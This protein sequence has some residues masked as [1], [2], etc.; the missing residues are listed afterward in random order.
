MNNNNYI[1]KHDFSILKAYNFLKILLLDKMFY[2]IVKTYNNKI[3]R[4]LMSKKPNLFKFD[5]Y[6]LAYLCKD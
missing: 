1:K 3:E 5:L 4:N 6:R 2:A